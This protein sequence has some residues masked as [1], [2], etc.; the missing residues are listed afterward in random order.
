MLDPSKYV[1][2]VPIGDMALTATN[3]ACVGTPKWYMGCYSYWDV[4]TDW[5]TPLYKAGF[6]R[7]L[8]WL[9]FGMGPLQTWGPF[10]LNGTTCSYQTPQAVDQYLL[11]KQMNFEPY[12][13]LLDTFGPA[14]KYFKLIHPEVQLIVYNG[15][16]MGCVRFDSGN[17]YNRLFAALAPILD[18]GC[19]LAF[20]S[21]CMI[22]AGHWLQRAYSMLGQKVYLESAPWRYP[23][24]TNMGFFCDLLQLRNLGPAN[25]KNLN[26]LQNG[27]WVGNWN[28]ATEL[29]TPT[30][31]RIG[32][33]FGEPLATYRKCIPRAFN[34]KQI[35]AIC[36]HQNM[37][38]DQGITLTA[39]EAGYDVTT[40]TNYGDYLTVPAPAKYFSHVLSR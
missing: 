5:L 12:R 40:E 39:L 34:S 8:I 22:P 25:E 24:M 18:V 38:L 31:D 15:T 11:T 3:P 16:A 7:Y 19:D 4:V 28:P 17:I 33:L 21:S 26:P 6:R 1:A 35:D 27:G 10:P 20:D 13:E 30:C 37:V 14:L 23:Y 9:P 36:L 2:F 29:T 32:A